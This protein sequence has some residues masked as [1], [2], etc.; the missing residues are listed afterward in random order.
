[1]RWEQYKRHKAELAVRLSNAEL[2]Q[3]QQKLNKKLDVLV[4]ER[5]VEL[6]K[7]NE[8]LHQASITDPLTGLFNRRHFD[9]NFSDFIRTLPMTDLR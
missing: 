3:T 7:T 6:E 5:T 2:L 8:Q 9:Q 1:M 4:R